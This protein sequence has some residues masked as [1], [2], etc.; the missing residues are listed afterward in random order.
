VDICRTKSS[1]KGNGSWLGASS[2]P[3]FRICFL[4]PRHYHGGMWV[5]RM[6]WQGKFLKPTAEPEAFDSCYWNF[7]KLIRQGGSA[8]QYHPA[9]GCSSKAFL[10]GG[11]TLIAETVQ[12]PTRSE[13]SIHQMRCTSTVQRCVPSGVVWKRMLRP[14]A[15]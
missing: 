15:K 11:T 14:Q 1:C 9:F 13:D 4:Y 6:G 12:S 7:P 8:K 10:N 3:S 5:T 2:S